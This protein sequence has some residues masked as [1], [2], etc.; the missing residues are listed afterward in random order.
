MLV[1]VG[2]PKLQLGLIDTNIPRLKT[3]NPTQIPSNL[4]IVQIIQEAHRSQKVAETFAYINLLYPK[5]IDQHIWKAQTFMVK[6]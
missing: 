3:R 5:R 2:L 4:K 6:T 1:K